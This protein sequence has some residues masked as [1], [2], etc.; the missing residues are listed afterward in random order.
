MFEH[1]EKQVDPSGALSE[2]ERAKLA[3][4]ARQAHL[5]GA[6][7]KALKAIRERQEPPAEKSDSTLASTLAEIIAT[8][9]LS[10]EA[11]IRIAELLG[12][13]R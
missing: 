10:S 6:R 1:F 2:K 4:N 8:V 3:E 7:R 12:G 5:A 11:R 13:D 9:E